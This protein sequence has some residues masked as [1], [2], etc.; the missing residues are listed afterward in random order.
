MM[1][2]ACTKIK[3]FQ[4]QCPEMWLLFEAISYVLCFHKYMCLIPSVLL[5]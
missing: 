5:M 3:T 1:C 4:S 2:I